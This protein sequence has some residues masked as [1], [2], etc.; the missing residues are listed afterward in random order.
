MGIERVEEGKGLA[1][2]EKEV[3]KEV[4]RVEGVAGELG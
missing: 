1:W 3:D 4:G 2:V